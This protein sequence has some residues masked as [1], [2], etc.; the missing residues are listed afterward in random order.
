MR[1]IVIIGLIIVLSGCSLV[2]PAPPSCQG[3]FHPVN[4]PKER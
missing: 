1:K 2:P 3:E 4:Q